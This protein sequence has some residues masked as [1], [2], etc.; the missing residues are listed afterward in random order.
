MTNSFSYSVDLKSSVKVLERKLENKDDE[1][2]A[3][4]KKFVRAFWFFFSIDSYGGSYSFSSD[5]SNSVLTTYYYFISTV[6]S[7]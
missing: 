3:C 1:I 6:D 7:H 2:K 5:F 4:R